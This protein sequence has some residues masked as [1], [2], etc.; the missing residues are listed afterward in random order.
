[1][2]TIVPELYVSCQNV[3]TSDHKPIKFLG[4]IKLEQDSFER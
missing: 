3:V 2:L 4:R 1:M